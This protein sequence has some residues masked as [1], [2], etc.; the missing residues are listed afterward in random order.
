MFEREIITFA[1]FQNSSKQTSF[2]TLALSIKE[3]R[4][5]SQ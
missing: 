1:V 5:I 2:K 3:Q 4:V